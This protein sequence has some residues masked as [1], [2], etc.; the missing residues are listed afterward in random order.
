VGQKHGD[1]RVDLRPEVAA[2]R[3]ER[4]VEIE[5]PGVDM[6]KARARF[7]W[8]QGRRRF[9]L[10]PLVGGIRRGPGPGGGQIDSVGVP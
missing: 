8:Q 7:R 3:I 2:G 9:Q 5:D 10:A 6:G 4:V 1:A